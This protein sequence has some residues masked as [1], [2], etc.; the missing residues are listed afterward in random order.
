MQNFPPVALVLAGLLALA[1]PARAADCPDLLLSPIDLEAI[2]D[3][4]VRPLAGLIDARQVTIAPAEACYVRI[5]LRLKGLPPALPGC[6]MNAC[7]VADF[8]GT[9]IALHEFEIQGCDPLFQLARLP[10]HVPTA[11]TDA[12]ERIATQCGAPDYQIDAVAPIQTPAGPQVRV[13]FVHKP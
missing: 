10:R 11:Y 12:A 7:S 6:Q 2:L 9:R 13:H 4:A 8:S 3:R 1:A 5:D